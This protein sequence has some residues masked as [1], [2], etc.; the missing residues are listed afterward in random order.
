[1]KNKTILL[2]SVMTCLTLKAAETTIPN[3][4]IDYR[5]YLKVAQQ[6]E[7]PRERRRLAF[8]VAIKW[9]FPARKRITLPV[10]VIL[11]RLATALRVLIPFGRRI[12]IT[13]SKRA[14]NISNEG[15]VIKRY[16]RKFW[17][18][19]RAIH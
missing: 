9:R 10:P 2:C 18:P 4:L 19:P 3:R 15:P 6:V 14:G 8:L 11:N 5:G 17:L 12:L 7:Q 16:F 13:F 1:M